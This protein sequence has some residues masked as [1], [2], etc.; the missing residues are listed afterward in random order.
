MNTVP[1]LT[2]LAGWIF[3]IF[4]AFVGGTII[5]LV[6]RPVKPGEKKAHIDL[7]QLVSEPTGDASMS[8]FQL[9]IFTFVVALSFFL[10]VANS[11]TMPD[12]PGSVLSLIGISASSYLVSKGIQ[13]GAE[14]RTIQISPNTATVRANQAQQFKAAVSI[15]TAN[16][17]SWSLQA[18][19]GT[20]SPDGLYTAPDAATIT[21]AGGR[22]YATIKATSVDDPS[23]SDLAIVTLVA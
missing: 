13:S 11:K 1:T 17:V 15:D 23:L 7:S 19:A 22:S 4:I 18:G 10:V 20:L 5:F 9:L 12:I 16:K 6:I 8:R 2:L 21:A 3:C 14:N